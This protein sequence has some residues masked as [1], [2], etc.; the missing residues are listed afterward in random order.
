M[1]TPFCSWSILERS[2]DFPPSHGPRRFSFLYLCADGVAAFQALYVA[3]R[4]LPAIVAIIQPGHGFGMNW[5]N[6][7]DPEKIFAQS[8]LE[9]PAGKPTILLY[10]GIGRRSFYEQPCWPE[11]TKRVCFLRKAGGGSIGVWQH[12]QQQQLAADGAALHR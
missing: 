2:N 1:K 5:T 3:N 8:V 10:G 4:A 6:F 9:N 7:T 11:Y 12:A